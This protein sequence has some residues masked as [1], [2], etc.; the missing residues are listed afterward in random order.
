MPAA[1]VYRLHTYL[2]DTSSLSH[3]QWFYYY[4]YILNTKPNTVNLFVYDESE[5]RKIQK[6]RKRIEE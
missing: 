4:Y 5:A 2:Y 1:I 6:Q 3:R